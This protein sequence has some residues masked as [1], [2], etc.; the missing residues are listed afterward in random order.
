MAEIKNFNKQVNVIGLMK[1]NRM[2]TI[3]NKNYKA[4]NLNAITSHRK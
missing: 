2:V 3:G 1:M 4:T